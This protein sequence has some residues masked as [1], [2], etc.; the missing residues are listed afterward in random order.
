MYSYL[1]K[2]IFITL[3]FAVSIALVWEGVKLGP[4]EVVVS[5]DSGN[6]LGKE[7]YKDSFAVIEGEI[8]DEDVPRI[9][10]VLGESDD[11]EL[12]YKKNLI[13]LP[14]VSGDYYYG[15][16][17]NAAAAARELN[18]MGVLNPGDRKSVI[19]NGYVTMNSN[20]GYISPGA[21]FM[22]ASGACWATSS[23]GTL[24]DE[25]NKEFN[26]T[27]GM[28]LFVF[29]YG[30]RLPHPHAYSTYA[31]SN[32][33]YGYSVVKRPGGYNSDYKFTVNPELSDHPVLKDIKIKIVMVSR[34]DNPNAFLGQSIGGY[35]MSSVDW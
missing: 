19:G 9:A 8:P 4:K 5:Q 25:V 17:I 14:L 1:K 34:E 12:I 33:G 28:D 10:H 13:E 6:F 16:Y 29:Q 23:L 24:M 20:R 22:Y 2:Y 31:P 15:K 30:D 7:A 32:W 11:K 27:Y 21:G 26:L 35:V 3:F 18:F